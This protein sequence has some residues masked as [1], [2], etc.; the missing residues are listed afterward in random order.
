MS[1]S[2]PPLTSGLRAGQGDSVMGAERCDGWG[3]QSM[4]FG[5]DR[6]QGRGLPRRGGC[7]PGAPNGDQRRSENTGAKHADPRMP[8]Y[9]RRISARA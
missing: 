6:L 5:R 1:P 2:L 4:Q 9:A 7:A 3:P 8:S